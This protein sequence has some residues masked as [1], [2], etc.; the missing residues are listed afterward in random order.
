MPPANAGNR[1]RAAVERLS[2]REL[3]VVRTFA[4]PAE[5]VFDAYT[6]PEHVAR[7]WAPESRGVSMA[8]CHAEI[9]PGGTYRYVLAHRA[10]WQMAFA[11]RYLEVER[12]W[13]LKYTQSWE[14][15][16]GRPAVGEAMI[17]TTF[18][19]RDGVTTLHSVETYPTKEALDQAIAS[20]MEEGI[21]DTF[22]LLDSL[23]GR[24]TA[25]G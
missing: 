9:R 3:R 8:E 15:Q 12:P 10:G 4:A 18:T 17:T 25:A 23:L 24:L 2:D 5:L 16:A 22:T 13:R 11:G 21:H 19:E 1:P 20:G 7:W 6:L 14:P